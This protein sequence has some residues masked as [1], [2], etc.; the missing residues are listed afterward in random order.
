MDRPI[1]FATGNKGK[2]R[3][4]LSILGDNF[5]REVV[6][7]GLDLPEF[8][9]TVT[10]CNLRHHIYILSIRLNIGMLQTG[11]GGGWWYSLKAL[12]M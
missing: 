12:L 9:G 5:P 6:N 2:L 8:Q 3:E 1:T 11:W 7:S 10:I 4:F